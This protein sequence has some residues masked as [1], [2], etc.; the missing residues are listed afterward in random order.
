[1]KPNKNNIPNEILHYSE[2]DEYKRYRR[3]RAVGILENIVFALMIIV[4][5]ALS[6]LLGRLWE[7]V[8]GAPVAKTQKSSYNTNFKRMILRIGGEYVIKI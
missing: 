8:N 4:L 5:V 3:A 6:F 7:Q 2:T 1:M